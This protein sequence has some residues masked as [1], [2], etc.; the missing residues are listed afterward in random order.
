MG[1]FFAFG[2]AGIG[3]LIIIYLT[4]RER[5]TTTALMSAR[6]MTY[7]QTVVILMAETLTMMIFAIFIGFLV[8][9]TIYYGLITG[10]AGGIPQLVEPLFLPPAFL[11]MFSLQNAILVGL[12]LLTTII[13]ILVEARVA[14][15][16]LSVLR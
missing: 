11:G 10:G 2:L 15:Y 16:D 4:L 3:T 14:R 8:G 5:R 9:L 7:T 1:V 6:G 13:P 12:L